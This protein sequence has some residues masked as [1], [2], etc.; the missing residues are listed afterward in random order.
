[1]KCSQDQDDFIQVVQ[2]KE[3]QQCITCDTDY[4][5]MITKTKCQFIDINL[6]MECI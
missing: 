3:I 2:I 1:M 4:V 6:L 5:N